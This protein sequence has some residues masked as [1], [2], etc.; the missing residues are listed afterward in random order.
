MPGCQHQ[1]DAWQQG[2][3]RVPQLDPWLER[4]QRRRLVPPA[5]EVD[6]EIPV[7]L[8][9]PDGRVGKGI[10]VP[11]PG[12]SDMVLV[13]VGEDDVGDLFRADARRD[14]GLQ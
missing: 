10:G 12:P 9:S 13:Q 14:Q 1:V 5:V 11:L 8:V 3:I 4:S 7:L 2:E 6:E